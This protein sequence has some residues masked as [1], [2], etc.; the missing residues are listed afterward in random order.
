MLTDRVIQAQK[1]VACFALSRNLR[2]NGGS[3]PPSALHTAG[4]EE[5]R[6]ESNNH[7]VAFFF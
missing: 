6:E 5:F 3:M 7:P 4:S 1:T 2:Q